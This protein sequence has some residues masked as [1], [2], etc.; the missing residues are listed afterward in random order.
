MNRRLFPAAALSAS[1]LAGAVRAAASGKGPAWIG[2]SVP[3]IGSHHVCCG[4]WNGSGPC[5]GGSC[6]RFTS[7]IPQGYKLS[8]NF[9]LPGT[10]L[11]GVRCE[12]MRMTSGHKL[13][14]P[15]PSS[16]AAVK[17]PVRTSAAMS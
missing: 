2:Y 11:R 3:A 16:R 8:L 17:P 6:A 15:I 1:D 12:V 14:P 10:S 7:P 9:D 5:G 4:N 13:D